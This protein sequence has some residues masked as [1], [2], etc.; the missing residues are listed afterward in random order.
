M[1][2]YTATFHVTGRMNHVFEA[3]NDEAAKAHL[4]TVCADGEFDLDDVCDVDYFGP[5][6]MH[7]VSRDGQDLWVSKVRPGDKPRPDHEV[8]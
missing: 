1:P 4:D 3:D 6:L 5:T 2:K 8:A 7:P